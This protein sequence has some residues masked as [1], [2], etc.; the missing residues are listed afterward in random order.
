MSRVVESNRTASIGLGGG[1]RAFAGG[2]AFVVGTPSVWGYALV[3]IL[4]FLVLL[5]SLGALGGWGAFR[6]SAALL[7]EPSGFWSGLGSWMLTVTLAIL[8][9]ILAM[10]VALSL[11]Q[12]ISGFALEAIVQAHER[13]LTGTVLAKP[14]L[15]V[16]TFKSFQ[17]TL[18]GLLVGVPV[19]MTLVVLNFCFPPALAVTVPLKF[20]VCSW[21]LAWNFL[22]Y[23]LGIRGLG[24]MARV[25]WIR[26]HFDAFSAFGMAWTALLIL[27][28]IILVLLPMGVAGAAQLVVE[29]EGNPIGRSDL[30]AR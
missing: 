1:L 24:V 12:P 7:G 2:I 20:L 14:G 25:R 22:D 18:A 30:M 26:Q 11:A 19:L 6:I 29:T 9:C 16:S 15:I 17:V 27:P 8:A 23:P 10:L 13:A 28:G 3:P 5:V 21:L 4:V